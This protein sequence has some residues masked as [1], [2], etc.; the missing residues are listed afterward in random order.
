MKSQIFDIQEGQTVWLC[1][2]GN[3]A[4]GKKSERYTKGVITQVARKY[5]YVHICGQPEQYL[6]RFLKEDFSSACASD[7]NAGYLIYPTEED[8]L[9]DEKCSK[10]LKQIRDCMM[11]FNIEFD[12]SEIQQIYTILKSHGHIKEENI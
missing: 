5:F 12:K 10:M 2:T 8:L 6:E 7:R 1:P 11:R 3:N 9:N 4:Y